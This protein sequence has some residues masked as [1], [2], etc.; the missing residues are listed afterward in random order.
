[1][2]G[3]LLKVG[4]SEFAGYLNEKLVSNFEEEGQVGRVE[5]RKKVKLEGLNL[6]DI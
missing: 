5:F 3:T 2:D 4:R 1:M 6:Q